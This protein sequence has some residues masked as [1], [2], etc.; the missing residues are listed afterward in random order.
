MSVH[1]RKF[2]TR[3]TSRAAIG[4]AGLTLLAATGVAF[5]GSAGAAT[6]PP[7]PESLTACDGGVSADPGAKAA[8]EPN[9]LRYRFNCD[10]GI[11]SYTIIVNRGAGDDSTIDDF[12]PTADVI[13]PYGAPS[14]TESVTCEGSTP[15]DGVN[16]NAGAGGVISS[17]NVVQGS[18]D[19]TGVYC[20]SLPRRGKPGAAAIPQAN[21]QL[22]VTDNTGAEDGP[23]D[24]RAIKRCPAVPNVVPANAKSKGAR[25]HGK[26]ARR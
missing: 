21:V 24:L 26:S 1:H 22:I 2:L 3:L 16:C 4:G 17:S 8:G 12:S 5:T 19:L 20:K 10:T 18:V 23:F 11:T 25:K 13:L 6:A 15:S 7:T 9:L 14:T